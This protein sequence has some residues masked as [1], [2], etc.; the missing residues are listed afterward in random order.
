[1]KNLFPSYCSVCF[2]LKAHY[3][4]KFTMHVNLPDFRVQILQSI[5]GLRIGHFWHWFGWTYK[6]WCAHAQM[7]SKLVSNGTPL[8][9]SQ[10]VRSLL[11]CC[12]ADQIFA[13]HRYRS[14][15]TITGCFCQSELLTPEPKVA[16]RQNEQL[17]KRKS[18]SAE[19]NV[20]LLM[21]HLYWKVWSLW[22]VIWYTKELEVS[23]L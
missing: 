19:K 10:S 2:R 20:K 22:N 16:V 13:L 15:S 9:C 14:T 11:L 21:I 8:V 17:T 6:K 3:P 1:M 23:Q 4:L 7:W 5:T 18:F 12:C